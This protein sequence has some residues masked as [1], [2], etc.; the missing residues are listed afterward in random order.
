[1]SSTETSTAFPPD[2]VIRQ[3]AL[4][5][6]KDPELKDALNHV[7]VGQQSKQQFE[8]FQTRA[9]ELKATCQPS[10]LDD[11]TKDVLGDFIDDDIDTYNIT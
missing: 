8:I 3:L 11:E 10:D 5:A 1:M 6:E 9:A 7:A 2:A 4:A